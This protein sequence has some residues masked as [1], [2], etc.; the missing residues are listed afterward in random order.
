MEG[1]RKSGVR[2]YN[3]QRVPTYTTTILQL[4]NIHRSAMGFI[5]CTGGLDGC[6]TTSGIIN[7]DQTKRGQVKKKTCVWQGQMGS[8]CADV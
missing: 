3:K 1:K 5:V 7:V 8:R 6:D 2:F 4:N